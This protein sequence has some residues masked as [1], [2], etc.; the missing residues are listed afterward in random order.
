M[1]SR[2]QTQ[3]QSTSAAAEACREQVLHLLQ[4]GL[5]ESAEVLCS[6]ALSAFA[7]GTVGAEGGG[8]SA[9]FSEL[10][11]DSLFAQGQFKRASSYFQRALQESGGGVGRSRMGTPPRRATAAA[12]LK[13]RARLTYKSALCLVELRDASSAVKLLESIPDTLKNVKVCIAMGKLYSELGLK[14][15]A[16]SSWKQVLTLLPS[17]VEAI[18]NLG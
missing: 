6:F 13:E 10:L 8:S 1:T 5:F 4:D 11:G 14:K 2:G 3:T 9:V 17:S 7:T 12:D 16:A 15:S 18:E